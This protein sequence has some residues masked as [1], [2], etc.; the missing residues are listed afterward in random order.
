MYPLIRLSFL[1]AL[2]FEFPTYIDC[3]WDKQALVFVPIFEAGFSNQ[4]L[5]L[6]LY[7][8]A[9]SNSQSYQVLEKEELIGLLNP[10]KAA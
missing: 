5:V 1:S 3:F 6:C 4:I 8:W 7:L 10:Y 2:A 9:L